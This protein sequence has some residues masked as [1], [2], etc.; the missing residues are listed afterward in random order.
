MYAEV[1]DQPWEEKDDWACLD[2]WDQHDEDWQPR[3]EYAL[4]N[5]KIWRWLL[6]HHFDLFGWIESGLAIKAEN[7]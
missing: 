2:W 7:P 6:V 4:G 5:T 3:S 1:T